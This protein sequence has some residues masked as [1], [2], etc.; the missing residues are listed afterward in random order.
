MSNNPINLTLRFILE[1]VMLYCLGYWGWT[2]H[3]G[4]VRVLLGIGVP[5]IAAT[6]WGVFRVPGYP[7]DAVVAVP[8]W[9]RLLL[10]WS[11]FTAATAALYAAGQEQWALIFGVVVILHYVASYDYVLAMLRYR[12][13]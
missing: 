2:Q 4:V 12:Y 11:L 10:E 5:I 6:L 13:E 1:L 8:G 7:K 9:V 3:E